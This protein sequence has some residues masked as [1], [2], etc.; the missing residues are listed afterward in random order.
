MTGKVFTR[1]AAA[2]GTLLALAGGPSRAAMVEPV[3]LELVIATD[4]SPSIDATE[5]R[6]QR[7]G[8]AE[9]FLDP[10]VVDAIQSGSLGKIA[11]AAIDFSSREYNRVAADWQ[12]I[13]DQKS[14]AAF[15]E[16]MR[17]T[18]ARPGRRTSISDGIELAQLLIETNLF[19]GTRK[20]IDVSGDGRNNW[21][22]PVN[23]VRNEA[24]AKGI[25]I[26]GLPILGSAAGLDAYFTDCVIGGPAAFVVPA[27]GFS[28]FARAVRNKLIQEI[29]QERR[30]GE[31]NLLVKVQ[32]QA[33][34]PRGGY[35]RP[36]NDTG[37]ENVFG[38]FPS[39][40]GFDFP[41]PVPR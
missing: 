18:P 10:R 2:L 14:A 20:A 39:F 34:L 32:A 28:D 17:R 4:V 1:M 5:A 35:T 25:T 33:P 11:V 30:N 29:A 23:I 19:L 6:L 21:G 41:L 16:H 13:K 31:P 22:R 7:E 8:I 15:A 38:G 37:C 24:V 36:L 12:V 40:R 26:N 27:H 9:A 3:D